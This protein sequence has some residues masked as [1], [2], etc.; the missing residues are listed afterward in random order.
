MPVKF[1]GET[2]RRLFKIWDDTYEDKDFTLDIENM[3]A[4]VTLDIIGMWLL[5][6][7]NNNNT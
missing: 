3:M 5:I 4:R 1:F 2:A 7:I 6:I